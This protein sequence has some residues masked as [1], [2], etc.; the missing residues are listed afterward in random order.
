MPCLNHG[1]T[2]GED[3][4]YVISI[5]APSNIFAD[6]SKAV[7]LLWFNMSVFACICPGEIFILD[8]RL[9]S[10]WENCPFGL[11]HVVFWLWCLCLKCVLLSIWCLGRKEL[12]NGIDSWS[13]TSFLFRRERFI[14]LLAKLFVSFFD[15]VFVSSL[16]KNIYFIVW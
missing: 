11:L 12:D 15:I 10:L 9:A 6:R 14:R 2:K 7:L 1:T 8:S 3:W 5:K 16:G 13:L 4:G